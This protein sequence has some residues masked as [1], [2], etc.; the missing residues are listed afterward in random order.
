MDGSEWIED[1]VRYRGLVLKGKLSHWCWDWD[2][3]PVDET[4][5]EFDCCTC[6]TKE[7]KENAKT[8]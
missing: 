5:G 6:Y 3:L 7:E 1:C 4:T 2:G 8:R